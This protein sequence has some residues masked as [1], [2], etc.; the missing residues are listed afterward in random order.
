MSSSPLPTTSGGAHIFPSPP[1]PRHRRCCQVIVA[2]AAPPR[3]YGVGRR[4][5]SLA[6]VAAWLA[7]T[8]GRADA[9]SPFDKYV[10]RKK[11][12]PLETYVPA[13]LLT[14]DQFVDLE[15]SLEFEKPRYDESRSLLRSGP[16]S[17]L[18]VNI[19]AVAQYASSNGQGKAASDA[20]DECLRALEDLDSLL[21]HASRNDPSASVETMRS[22]ISVALAALDNLLQ[23]V[24]SAVLDK[25]KAI[26]DAYR[27][28]VDDYVEENAAELDPRLKQLEDIL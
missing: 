1:R 24:P 3:S 17:S 12:E 2:A 7:T 27:T 11:L 16:A 13:V 8:V 23:T 22:K 28:P 21:L 9:A 10:K 20:V 25:G 19:R 14:I 18:R 6:G 4:A 15:K 5:V 26:A